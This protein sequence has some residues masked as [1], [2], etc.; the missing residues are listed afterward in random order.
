[1]MMYRIKCL[2]A[3]VDDEDRRE[4]LHVLG[5]VIKNKLADLNPRVCS[6]RF[7]RDTNYERTGNALSYQEGRQD[8]RIE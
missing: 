2:P 4:C 8:E 1:M 7:G 6:E 3:L 5:G